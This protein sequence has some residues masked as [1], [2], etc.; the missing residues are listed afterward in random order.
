MKS[1][2]LHISGMIVSRKRARRWRIQKQAVVHENL[3]D[4]I[5][6]ARFEEKLADE[7]KRFG[8]SFAPTFAAAR[9]TEWTQLIL[10]QKAAIVAQFERE[11]ERLHIPV[12]LKMLQQLKAAR[13]ERKENLYRAAVRERRGEMTAWARDRRKLGYPAPV[14]N[15]WSPEKRRRMLIVRRSVSQVGYVGMLKR[16]MGWKIRPLEDQYSPE[17]YARLK[18]SELA[19]RRENIKRRREQML[20][21]GVDGGEKHT[22]PS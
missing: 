21:L 22:R 20:E 5:N 2:P 12:P 8:Q 15:R 3:L 11:N 4:L 6:E 17:E 10:E 7:A 18:K 14:M 1:Q 16:Q 19:I 9:E 13:K